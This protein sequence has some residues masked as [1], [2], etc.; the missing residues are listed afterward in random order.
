MDPIFIT[1][2]NPGYSIGADAC[3][4]TQNLKMDFYF[5]S[6]FPINHISE[7]GITVL[8]LRWL[9]SSNG[10]LVVSGI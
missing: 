4:I 1:S 10:H 5:I 3:F 7:T 6:P 9:G 8:P 2:D